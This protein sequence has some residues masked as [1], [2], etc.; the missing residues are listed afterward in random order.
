MSLG[1]LC[2]SGINNAI[3]IKKFKGL[4]AR[5][6]CHIQQLLHTYI[7]STCPIGH[8]DAVFEGHIP[9]GEAVEHSCSI[10]ISSD[11]VNVVHIRCLRYSLS[12]AMRLP[13]SHALYIL[14]IYL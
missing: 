9:V 11:K 3:T 2:T 4:G 6:Y 14:W 7:A 12:E 13:C 5:S 10:R 1:A 8:C